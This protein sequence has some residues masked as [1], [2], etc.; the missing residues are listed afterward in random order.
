VLLCKLMHNSHY[1]L[2]QTYAL[3]SLQSDE[4]H[5]SCSQMRPDRLIVKLIVYTGTNRQPLLLPD[6]TGGSD[7][8][9]L[10]ECK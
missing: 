8:C 1:L 4:N 7:Y 10:K 6:N 3:L 5:Q 9:S 2:V